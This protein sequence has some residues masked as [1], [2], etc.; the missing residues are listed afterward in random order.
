M[1]A[2]RDAVFVKVRILSGR[3][4]ELEKRERNHA[5][6][7]EFH[8]GLQDARLDIQKALIESLSRS[9]SLLEA[10]VK[11]LQGKPEMS[12][13]DFVSPQPS[14][15]SVKVADETPDS[16]MARLLGR[17]GMVTVFDSHGRYLGCMGQERW[18]GQA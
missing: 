2:F 4:A 15:H 17:E 13:G 6:R 3:V 10:A 14:E 11:D 8:D 12:I 9:V 7:L 16:T 5:E 18:E 1:A